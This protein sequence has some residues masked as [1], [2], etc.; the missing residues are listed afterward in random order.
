LRLFHG[1]PSLQGFSTEANA[2]IRTDADGRW[3]IAHEYEDEAFTIL[4]DLENKSEDDP[5]II[6]QHKEIV[7]TVQYERDNAVAWS[8]LLTGKTGSKGGTKTV[9][10]LLLGMGSQAIQQL[11]GKCCKIQSSIL[12]DC[13]RYQRYQL[14]S[15]DRSDRIRWSEQ[16]YGPSLSRL[17][18]RFIPIVLYD[19]HP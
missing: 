13:V 3:L 1:S 9:R 5:F 4:A 18:Q 17:Q 16:Q 6:A 7:Y 2:A 10:R 19:R 14:L 12:A 11:S 8:K 15:S